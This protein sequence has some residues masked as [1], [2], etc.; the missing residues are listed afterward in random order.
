MAG[1]RY[2]VDPAHLFRS[3]ELEGLTALFHLPS[4][5]T[6]IL[7]PPAPQI[8]QALG[9]GPADAGELT[10]RLAEWFELDGGSEAMAGRLVELEAAGLLKRA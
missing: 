5:M 2:I 3:V 10:E 4:G 8:L 9:R 6:H 1:I 7:A